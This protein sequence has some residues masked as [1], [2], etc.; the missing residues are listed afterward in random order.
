M[1]LLACSFLSIFLV[2][3]ASG[4]PDRSL[5]DWKENRKL[6]WSDFRASPARHTPI[7]ALSSTS[8]RVDF[9]FSD[10]SMRYHIRC[11]FDKN[12][13]W[14][15]VRNNYILSHEQLH[16]DIAEWY[17]R[18][19]NKI[20]REYTRLGKEHEQEVGRIYDRTMKEYRDTQERYDHQTSYS[21]NHGEQRLWSEKVHKALDEL[22]PYAGYH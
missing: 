1:Q 13:S 4:S 3:L 17:A 19:L 16:F 18:K 21:I 8:I 9:E 20:L 12:S 5:I 14:G 15:R 10:Q 22:S 7:A 6:A 11:Q 2:T